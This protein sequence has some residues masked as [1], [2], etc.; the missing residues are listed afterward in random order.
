MGNCQTKETRPLRLNEI[1]QV[2]RITRRIRILE[3]ERIIL[4]RRIAAFNSFALMVCVEGAVIPRDE[5]ITWL[6]LHLSD[7]N[8]I[9]ERS[10]VRDLLTRLQ[11]DSNRIDHRFEERDLL[12]NPEFTLPIRGNRIRESSLSDH[13]NPEFIQQQEDILAL[14]Q[15]EENED[16]G[17]PVTYN[18]KQCDQDEMKCY[19]CLED[20][21]KGNFAVKCQRCPSFIHSTCAEQGNL[22][23]CGTCR[24]LL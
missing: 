9:D 11:L 3:E 17:A 1:N 22:R 7:T 18:M 8:T 6:N 16:Q 13:Y 10:F 2:G 19:I 15:Q 14:T 4:Q 12:Y 20:I 23:R 24:N 5:F 21:A